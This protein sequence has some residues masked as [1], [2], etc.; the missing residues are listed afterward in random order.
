MKVHWNNKG[1]T[2]DFAS[3]RPGR[4]FEYGSCLYIKCNAKQ[5]A[6]RMTDGA[7]YDDM[8]GQQVIPINAEVHIIN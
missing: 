5:Q 8:C 2:V 1:S 7:V 6:V 3:I 4:C